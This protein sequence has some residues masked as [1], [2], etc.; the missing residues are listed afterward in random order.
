VRIGNPMFDMGAFV[1]RVA[2]VA[3]IAVLL[4]GCAAVK[5]AY[6]NVDT[7]VRF[8]AGDYVSLDATQK[9]SFRTRLARLHSWH[10]THE[11]PTYAALLETARDRVAKGLSSEDV[12]RGAEAVRG[13]YRR[14]AT[15]AAAEAAPIL[16][17][18]SPEQIGDMERK[19]AES[20]AKY[21]REHHLDDAPN[22]HRKH[23]RQMNKRFEDWMGSLNDAQEARIERFVRAHDEMASLRLHDRI[24]RQKAGLALIRAERDAT[25]LAPRLAALF[26]QPEIG[27][28]E[29]YRAA[30]V[31][32]NADL[33][34]LVMD[35]EREA[36]PEQRARV[37]ERM[38]DYA[39]DFR[40]LSA[41]TGPEK[42]P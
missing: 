12:D 22:R 10:R 2:L 24:R 28:S 37:V 21:A 32:Y 39:A 27:R 26:A 35:I 5:I 19:L 13:F 40:A 6:N 20:N 23:V 36:T 8:M 31:R 18:L 1:A 9:E 34:L 11:L 15:R 38:D 14:L 30:A 41:Q 4:G 16:V 7:V 17:T 33:A 42:A 3:L 29:P 25:A